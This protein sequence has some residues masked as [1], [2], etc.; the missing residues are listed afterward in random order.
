[1]TV[2]QKIINALQFIR[3]PV[4]A[5]FF[6]GGKEEYVT[7]NYVTDKGVVFADNE[8]TEDVVTLQIHYFLPSEKNYLDN[9]R[10]IRKA[11]LGAGCTYPD[12]TVLMEPDNKTRHVA[13][14]C[15]IENEYELEE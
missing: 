11:L 4:T 15:E 7:F 3:I 2:N 5:D 6:G 9:K 14:E 1:M 10:K 12:V 13:F 8:P